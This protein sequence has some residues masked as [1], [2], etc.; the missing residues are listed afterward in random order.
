[1]SDDY[2]PHTF[3]PGAHALGAHP[4]A[5]RRVT[6]LQ[7]IILGVIEGITEFLP[8]SSTGHLT[9]TEQLMGLPIDSAGIT[10]FTAVIQTGAIVAVL[11]YFWHDIVRLLAAWWRGIRHPEHRGDPDH[12]LAWY[13]ALGSL[14]ILFIGFGLR[15][16]IS[17]SLRNLWVVVVALIAWSFVMIAAERLSRRDR[18]VAQLTLVDAIIIGAYQCIALIPGVSRSG[19]TISGGLFRNLDRVTATRVSFLLSIPALLAA[20]GYEVLSSAKDIG[21]TVGWGPTALATLISFVV[22]YASIAWLLRLVAGHPI[23]VFVPYRIGLAVV[24]AALLLTGTL[25][26]T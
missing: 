2:G 13:I 8:I 10:A 22:A 7:A 26:A 18:G 17:G 21:D 5:R 24:V 4:D 12:R 14:P 19:A 9:I 20:G 25:T 6:W 11:L 3:R 15:H 1:V 23:S 16:F